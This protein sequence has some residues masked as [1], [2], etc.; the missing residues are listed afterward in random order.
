MKNKWVQLD[1]AKLE[2][3]SLEMDMTGLD[4]AREA[5]I[6]ERTWFRITGN[7]YRTTFQNCCAIAFVLGISPDVLSPDIAKRKDR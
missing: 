2:S 1:I 7:G 3:Q 6:S 5:R 4:V